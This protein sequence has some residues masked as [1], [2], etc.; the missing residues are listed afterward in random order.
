METLPP[1]STKPILPLN[2]ILIII[3]G[4]STILTIFFLFQNW[5]LSQKLSSILKTQKSQ[6]I[7]VTVSPTPSCRPRPV[8]L[9]S[10][11]ACKIVETPDMCPKATENTST[12]QTYS[13][14]QYGYRFQYPPGLKVYSEIES[15]VN[16]TYIPVCDP[17]VKSCLFIPA[18]KYL[19]TNFKGGGLGVSITKAATTGDCN[20]NNQDTMPTNLGDQT[21][22]N[23]TY[24]RYSQGSAAAGNQASELKYYTFQNKQCYLITST[25]TTDSSDVNVPGGKTRT[26]SPIE[27]EQFNQFIDNIL[28]TFKFFPIT[29]QPTITTPQSGSTINSPLI[30]KGTVPQGWMF[31]GVFSIKLLDENHKLITIAQGKEITPGDSYGSLPINFTSKLNF[32]TNSATGFLDL[33]KD[34]PS[35]LPEKNESFE[36]PIKFK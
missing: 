20:L 14:P 27:I 15:F 8:C 13:L 32:Q 10:Y 18:E 19:G 34:N 17:L 7:S 1:T 22:N 16:L 33:V 5:L 9:D 21:I 23:I 29:N 26:I 36:I 25:L 28:A 12:W 2:T 24:H 3:T 4:L 30:V 31:E 35:G 6:P 11:P